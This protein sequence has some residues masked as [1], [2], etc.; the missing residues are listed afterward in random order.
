MIHTSGR[1]NPYLT[2]EK[3]ADMVSKMGAPT[4]PLTNLLFPVSKRRQ[5]A[6]PFISVAEIQAETGAIPVN[7]R[8]SGSFSVDGTQGSTSIIEVSPVNPS[9]FIKGKEINDLIHLGDTVSITQLLTDRTTQ[10]RDIVSNTI[11][12]MVKQAM[13]GKISYPLFTGADISGTMDIEMG[14]INQLDS[15][16][17]KNHDFAKLQMWLEDLYNKQ[18]ATGAGIDIVYMMGIGVYSKVVNILTAM[19]NLAPVVWTHEGMTI[20]GKYKVLSMGLTYKLPGSSVLRSVISENEVRTFDKANAGLL[21]YASLNDLD[22]KLAPLPFYVKSLDTAD[23]SGIKLIAESK[24]L[25]ALAYS[26]MNQQIVAVA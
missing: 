2:R 3:I 15:I 18:A 11:E 10:L 22:A 19:G 26:K 13:S 23:P 16:N 5:K 4:T 12:T 7:V 17:I 9:L 21:F 25:P 1:L 8:G 24:P 20:L 6:S 14:R